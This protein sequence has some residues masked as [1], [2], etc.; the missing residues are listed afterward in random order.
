MTGT[1][2]SPRTQHSATLLAPN[3]ILIFGGCNSSGVFFNDSF[4][5]DTRNFSWHRPQHLNSTPAPR[6]HHT[7][8][9]LNNRVFLYGGINAKQTFE[10]V[11]VIET[12]F[13]TDLNFVAEELFRMSAEHQS[14]TSSH[15]SLPAFFGPLNSSSSI[16]DSVGITPPLSVQGFSGTSGIP[17]LS[18]ISANHSNFSSNNSLGVLSNNYCNNV[19]SGTG[20]TY[21]ENLAG[22]FSSHLMSNAPNY[23]SANFSNNMM[24]LNNLKKNDSDINNANSIE[25]G[26]NGNNNNNNNNSNNVSHTISNNNTLNNASIRNGGDRPSA[27][28]TSLMASMASLFANKTTGTEENSHRDIRDSNNND[29]DNGSNYNDTNTNTNTRSDGSNNVNMN[30]SAHNINANSCNNVVGSSTTNSDNNDNN[31][32]NNNNINNSNAN[33]S[34]MGG[35]VRGGIINATSRGLDSMKM[36][37]TDLLMKR[38]LEEMHAQAIM[39][40]E[41]AESRLTTEKEA[42]QALS[43]DLKALRLLHSESESKNAS[44]VTE[45]AD[46][47]QRSSRNA[48]AL[49]DARREISFL[50]STV[51]D[52]TSLCNKLK[53]DIEGTTK[54]LAQM[55]KTLRQVEAEKAAAQATVL[56]WQTKADAKVEQQVIERLEAVVKER[57]RQQ[58]EELE[59]GFEIQLKEMRKEVEAARAAKVESMRELR[60]V[61]ERSQREAKVLEFQ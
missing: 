28:T 55:A 40:A 3:L 52:Q 14:Q 56:T 23:N 8:N 61:E 13:S 29:S 35:S 41:T 53:G 49:S 24:A 11:V 58:Q 46:I 21:Q 20:A 37:L 32:N 57:L 12:K 44:L 15:Q 34:A 26:N 30:N 54:E 33:A 38:N 5:L 51:A 50:E 18:S 43:R 10:G 6:Y 42:R 1:P 25:N 27:P 39:K 45:L 19:V 48:A 22:F 7:C 59:R 9:V 60:E 16:G 2:P 36:Q 47:R 4:V 17:R 31:N